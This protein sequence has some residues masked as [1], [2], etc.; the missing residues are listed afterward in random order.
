MSRLFEPGVINGLELSN[1]LVRSATWEGLADEAGRATEALNRVMVQLAQGGIGLIIAS[2]TFVR[3]DGQA[4]PRQLGLYDDKLIPSFSAM[5]EAVHQAGGR[6]VAQLTH[7]GDRAE[8][9]LTKAPAMGPDQAGLDD[10][11]AL[12][13]AY[14][15]AAGR[16]KK[17]GFDGIQLH[18][19]HGYLINQFISPALNHRDDDY[20]GGL[21]NRA[22]F[23]LEVLAGVRREVGPDYP[24]LIKINGRDYL[25]GGLTIDQS[26]RICTLLARAG[27]DAIEVSGG[28]PKG[29]QLPSRKGITSPDKEAYHR[30]EAEAIK[31]AVDIPVMV[32]GGI[33]SFEVAEALLTD[34]AADYVSLC[35]PLIREPDLAARWQAGDRRPAT[36]HSDSLCFKP[37]LADQGFYCYLDREEEDKA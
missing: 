36:C 12:Q 23:A 16:A 35:R 8:T 25:S 18:S 10:I 3:P 24:V 15:L 31:K 2:H 26:S 11:R 13:E 5:T 29:D 33:R 19:A 27:L 21:E 9:K 14:I 6:I 22:R 28:N 7:A 34:G 20:G 30:A 32:V 37:I 1:R 17:A 4:G